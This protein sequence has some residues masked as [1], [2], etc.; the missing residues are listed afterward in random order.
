METAREGTE[1]KS[2]ETN[3]ISNEGSPRKQGQV[4]LQRDCTMGGARGQ[5]K[6]KWVTAEK[7]SAWQRIN[8]KKL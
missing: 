2:K 4:P 5:T 3:L 8:R 1:F 6:I 7:R